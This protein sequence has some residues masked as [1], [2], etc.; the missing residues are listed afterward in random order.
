MQVNA[1]L[2]R[3]ARKF[4]RRR[5][6]VVHGASLCPEDLAAAAY[7][8][9]LRYNRGLLAHED[10]QWALLRWIAHR[11]FIATTKQGYR[12]SPQGAAGIASQLTFHG[13]AEE[14]FAMHALDTQLRDFIEWARRADA[15]PENVDQLLDL[16]EDA[17]Q[18]WCWAAERYT[19]NRTPTKARLALFCNT[20]WRSMDD[21]VQWL[22]SAYM[23][24][25]QSCS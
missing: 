24:G 5:A 11:V 14:V 19:D 6:S 12:H 20:T 4:T 10:V 13:T 25:M 15:A 8:H 9:L 2:L 7:E 17:T 16:L 23:E 1:F 3:S 22:R 21:A 18:Y